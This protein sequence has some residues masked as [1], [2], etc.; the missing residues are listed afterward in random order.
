MAT[1]ILLGLGVIMIGLMLR[2]KHKHDTW[3]QRYEANR[4]KYEGMRP[5]G[6]DQQP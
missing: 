2:I 5:E 3:R 6:E 4:Q 1:L